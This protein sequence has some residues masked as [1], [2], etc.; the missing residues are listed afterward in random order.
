M[1]W[2]APKVEI[3]FKTSLAG[4]DNWVDVTADVLSSITIRRGRQSELETYSAGTC[5]FDLI[6]RNRNYDFTYASGPYFGKLLPR[7]ECRVTT[8]FLSVTYNLF[9]GFIQG[10]PQTYDNMTQMSTVKVE[11]IDRFDILAQTKLLSGVATS[12]LK[13]LVPYFWFRSVYSNGVDSDSDPTKVIKTTPRED[14]T[15]VLKFDG[16]SWANSSDGNPIQADVADKSVAR[17]VNTDTPLASSV[18]SVPGASRMLP[19]SNTWSMG[20]WFRTRSVADQPNTFGSAS[21]LLIG[22]SLGGGAELLWQWSSLPNGI[23]SRLRASFKH[24]TGGFVSTFIN[25]DFNYADDTWHHIVITNAPSAFKLFVDGVE[26]GSSNALGSATLDDTVGLTIAQSVEWNGWFYDIFGF[27]RTLS[28]AE[29]TN[30]YQAGINLPNQVSGN[31][32]NSLLTLF[33]LGSIPT[34]I[35][36]G[37]SIIAD[38]SPYTGSSMLDV[39]QEVANAEN[40]QLYIDTNG[41]LVFHGRLDILTQTRSTTLQATFDDTGSNIP[42]LEA[43]PTL[44]IQF[45][46]NQINTSVSG[47]TEYQTNDVPNQTAYGVRSLDR[48]GLALRNENDAISQAQWNLIKYATPKARLPFIVVDP[49]VSNAAMTAALSLTLLDRIRVARSPQGV[50]SAWSFDVHIEGIEMDIDL[51]NLDWKVTYNLTQTNIVAGFMQL[52]SS[53]SGRLD[54]AKLAG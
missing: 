21:M 4:T 51:P 6:N 54:T 3:N 11:A 28:Q 53:T 24:V 19:V 49:R 46:Y 41:T 36:Q 10:W 5:S 27:D 50:G 39:L 8:T 35:A 16:N 45:M 47:G 40:G 38:A 9:R 15:Q 1:T 31:R 26:V 25:A 42:Y 30:L 29:I 18:A 22:G 48:A 12:Y 52:D 2:A 14:A 20:G 37:S 33:G 17:M 32:I 23:M 7:N 43:T 44:D 13:S 34:S